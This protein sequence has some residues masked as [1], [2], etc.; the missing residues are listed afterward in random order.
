MT[1]NDFMKNKTTKPG[2]SRGRADTY[3]IDENLIDLYHQ[4]LT[5]KEVMHD[6]ED[7]GRRPNHLGK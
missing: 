7:T 2:K 1:L 6:K 5:T 4:L 3:S